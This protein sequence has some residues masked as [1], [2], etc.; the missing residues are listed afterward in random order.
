MN[1]PYIRNEKY[2]SYPPGGL[3]P[4][5]RQRFPWTLIPVW[6]QIYLS[7]FPPPSTPTHALRT[8]VEGI[9]K[10][11]EITSHQDYWGRLTLT[12]WGV[13][14]WSLNSLHSEC[15]PVNALCVIRTNNQE[16][17][18][19]SLQHMMTMTETKHIYPF[20]TVCLMKPWTWL[21]TESIKQQ[22]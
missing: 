2:V 10:S 17:G 3:C 9:F 19:N 13:D 7:L 22:D 21:R 15:Q 20:D 18:L 4:N 16:F 6:F 11:E 8:A 14:S 5:V 12:L 1:F